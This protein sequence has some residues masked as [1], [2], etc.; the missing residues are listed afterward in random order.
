MS[1]K[2]NKKSRQHNANGF[3]IQKKQGLVFAVNKFHF[4]SAFRFR[5][6]IT[7]GFAL[8]EGFIVGLR[9]FFIGLGIILFGRLFTGGGFFERKTITHG[10]FKQT[11]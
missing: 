9:A 7:I 2:T 1:I 11:I 6:A 3:Q 10:I 4:R 8:A 5:E